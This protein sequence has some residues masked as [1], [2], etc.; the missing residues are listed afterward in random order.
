MV[1]LTVI[2]YK[3]FYQKKKNQ[4]LAL[5]YIRYCAYP[6]DSITT[7]FNEQFPPSFGGGVQKVTH[8][9]QVTFFIL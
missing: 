3:P 5:A 7:F 4:A 9:Y 2:K 1:F 8:F 6:V